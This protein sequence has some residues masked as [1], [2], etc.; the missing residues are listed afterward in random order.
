M[1]G[2][3]P[4]DSVAS[5]RRTL[6]FAVFPAIPVAFACLLPAVEAVAHERLFSPAIDPLAGA[7]SRRLKINQRYLQNSI[8][9]Y[10]LFA[11][12]LLGLARYCFDGMLKSLLR[13]DKEQGA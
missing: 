13:A 5:Q 8:E 12:G 1:T 11:P 9:Q 10:L 2:A 7:E 3:A 6:A 4:P